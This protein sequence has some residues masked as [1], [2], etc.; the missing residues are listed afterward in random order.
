MLNLG[1]CQCNDANMGVFWLRDDITNIASI[2]QT[3][4]NEIKDDERRSLS[5]VHLITSTEASFLAD[6]F[7]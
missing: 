6:S 7:N 2:T 5:R 4:M 3:T 1:A